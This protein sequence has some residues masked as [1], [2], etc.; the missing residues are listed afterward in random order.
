MEVIFWLKQDILVKTDN[1]TL[2]D[3]LKSSTGVKSR[4]LRI[5]IAAIKEMIARNEI[6]VEWVEN[7]EQLADVFTKDGKKAKKKAFRKF[8]YGKE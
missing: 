2:E 1:Q 7:T 8:M 5:D 6:Q 3:G 4:R